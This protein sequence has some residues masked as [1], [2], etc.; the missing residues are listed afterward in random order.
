MHQ[1]IIRIIVALLLNIGLMAPTAIIMYFLS[2]LNLSVCNLNENGQVTKLSNTSLKPWM[3][4][5]KDDVDMY[6]LRKADAVRHTVIINDFSQQFGFSNY[7]HTVGSCFLVTD[8]I[9][10]L[11]DIICCYILGGVA[12]IKSFPLTW[13]LICLWGI[14][15]TPTVICGLRIRRAANE[16]LPHTFIMSN[17][18]AFITTKET[19][20]EKIGSYIGMMNAVRSILSDE[21]IDEIVDSFDIRH[22]APTAETGKAIILRFADLLNKKRINGASWMFQFKQETWPI[23]NQVIEMAESSK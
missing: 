5:I 15:C 18:F 13:A 1:F 4:A 6:V 21:E 12:L 16:I 3:S 2:K 11:L 22:S 9:L 14:I 7:V 23:Y 17:I 20:P 8:S 10:I 19:N